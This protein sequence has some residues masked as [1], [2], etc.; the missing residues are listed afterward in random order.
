[1]CFCQS[2][3]AHQTRFSK[4]PK[5]FN[6]HSVAYRMG[7][8]HHVFNLKNIFEKQVLHRFAVEYERGATPD[9]CI[10]CNRFVKFDKFLLRVW[11][12]GIEYIAAG[13]YTCIPVW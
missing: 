1:M 12:L 4:G 13:Y 3:K 6:T 7:I 11:E 5:A 8:P 2:P 10:D 9:P